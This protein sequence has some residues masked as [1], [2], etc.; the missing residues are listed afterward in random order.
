[1]A[2]SS[3]TPL[4]ATVPMLR[5]LVPMACGIVAFEHCGSPVAPIA[6]AVVAAAVFV[7]LKVAA[8]RS[9]ERRQA[10]RPLHTVPIALAAMSVGWCAA[11]VQQPATLDTG[12]ING[13]VAVGRIDMI[14]FRDFS[15]V[16]NVTLLQRDNGAPLPHSIIRL[17][18]SGCDYS[19]R[20]G[21]LVAF[22]ADLQPVRNMGNPDE[23]DFAALLRQ[24]GI[25]YAQHIGPGQRLIKVGCAPT[26]LNKLGN[27]RTTM[28]RRIASGH[29]QQGTQDFVVALLLG[30]DSL[31]DSDTRRDFA[32]AGIAHVLALSGLHVG[33]IGLVV[34]WLL[35]PLDYVR[36]KRLRLA[37]TLVALAAFDMFTGLQPSVVRATVMTAFVTVAVMMGRKASPLNS[38]AAAATLT[39]LFS[40][41]ALHNAGFQLS[42]TTVAALLVFGR[43][44]ANA[45]TRSTLAYR[46]GTLAATSAI[47]SLSTMML[48]AHYFHSIPLLAVPV[49]MLILPTI[50]AF[51]VGGIAYVTLC[52]TGLDFAWLGKALD[53]YCQA[54]R[55]LVDGLC[56]MPGS[57]AEGLWVTSAEVAIYFGIMCCM[58]LWLKRRNRTP[59]LCAAALLAAGVA[60][61][62]VEAWRTPQ[63]GLVV[64]NSFDSTPIMAF[65]HGNAVVWVPDNDTFD[66]Q[67]FTDANSGFMAHHG[68][69]QL[70][71]VGELHNPE[72]LIKPP[73]AHLGSKRLVAIGHGR[74]KH[75]QRVRTR[76]QIDMAVITRQFHSDIGI[77]DSLYAGGIGT[78][79]ISGAAYASERKVLMERCSKL[80]LRTHDIATQGAV[81][82]YSR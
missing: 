21:Q 4:L 32:N 43:R 39:L 2:D 1:M 73:Y 16:A 45:A 67:R 36:L 80:G 82:V 33:L 35:M 53:A 5:I 12:R 3:R 26:L 75:A 31:I 65:S 44:T 23:T 81:E 72:A 55:W 66:M 34:W 57:H 56:A 28:M 59:L 38:L 6:A 52:A 70:R 63:S 22:K 30:D 11:L 41:S 7:A 74:W 14:S 8:R 68:I 58:A 47:A 64:F 50:P 48:T 19:L 15:A 62:A 54:M 13:T 51:M 25:I 61:A 79:V 18:T 60:H 40:P 76:L 46:I 27:A 24:Q 37:L 71:L 17:S 9:L 77:V 69:R 49:N 10:L 20:Q 29:T 42:Y 78:Y